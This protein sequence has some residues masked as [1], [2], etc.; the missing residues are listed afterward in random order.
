MGWAC[1]T[2][3]AA[4]NCFIVLAKPEENKATKEDL[5]VKVMVLK[6]M[7]KNGLGGCGLDSSG[8]GRRPMEGFCDNRNK[9]SRPLKCK[10]FLTA[11]KY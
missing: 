11:E 5:G 4:D 6:L 1:G 7:S 10:N 9:P 2:S 3:V 8:T